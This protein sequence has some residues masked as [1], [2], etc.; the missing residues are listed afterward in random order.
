MSELQL[1]KAA[2]L[3]ELKQNRE[4]TISVLGKRVAIF[5]EPGG[6]L[7]AIEV[8]CKHHGADLTTGKRHGSVVTCPR[9]GWQYDLVTGECLKG[10]SPPLRPHAV[11]L[12][13]EDVWVSLF[14]GAAGQE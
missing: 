8:T 14:P 3:S 6:R 11:E 13:G 5:L 12:R 4:K 1:I 2:T 9:H 7:R 10:N